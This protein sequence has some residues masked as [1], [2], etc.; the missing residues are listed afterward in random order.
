MTSL[1]KIAASI[2][3]IGLMAAAPVAMAN[4]GGALTLNPG[5]MPN[6]HSVSFADSFNTLG[7]FVDDWTF[8]LPTSVGATYSVNQFKH[9]DFF[10]NQTITGINS[11]HASLYHD[12]VSAL[13]LVPGADGLDFFASGGL[14]GGNYILRVT[15]T[16]AGIN[17]TVKGTYTGMMAV[18]PAVPEPDSYALFLAGLGLLSFI[19]RRRTAV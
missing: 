4:G 9:V 1:K 14:A 2:S 19:A 17:N 11:F 15:G 3:M 8:T 18:L 13:N 16:V 7:S 10:F 5:P 6:W 12:S